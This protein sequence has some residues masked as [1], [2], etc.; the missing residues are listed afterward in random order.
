MFDTED[1]T[2]AQ[3]QQDL[4]LILRNL[5]PSFNFPEPALND[6][7]DAVR[8][9][10][11]RGLSPDQTLVLVNSSRRHRSAQVNVLGSLGRGSNPVDLSTIPA[12]AIGRIEVLRDGAAAQYGSDAIAGIINVQLKEKRE[13]FDLST[14]YGRFYAGDGR[15]W[16]IQA[17]Q[18]F[19]L[20]D[21]GF[22][23]VSLEFVDA[24]ET[25]RAGPE[26]RAEAMRTLLEQGYFDGTP[27]ETD[28]RQV[29]DPGLGTPERD[30]LAITLNTGLDLGDDEE[31]YGFATFTDREIASQ[32]FFYREPFS[33]S[34]LLALS[35]DPAQVNTD[36]VPSIFPAGYQPVLTTDVTDV[37]ASGG[38]RGSLDSGLQ[39]DASLTYG[40]NEL[41]FELSQSL[42]ASLGPD[43]PTRFDTGAL[44]NSELTANLDFS[45]PVDIGL[46]SPLNVA[47]GAEYRWEEYAI[48]QGEPAS[49]AQGSSTTPDGRPRAPFSNGFPGFRPEDAI[50]ESRESGSVYLDLEADVTERLLLGAAMRYENY[51]DF[52]ETLNGKVSARYEVN[53]MLALRGSASTGFRA[54][55]LAQSYFTRIQAV[56]DADTNE[57]EETGVFPVSSQAAQAFGAQELEPEDSVNFTGGF[58]VEPFPGG[59]FEFDLYQIQLE[60]RIILTETLE[61]DAAERATLD[62]IGLS[63]VQAVQFFVNGVD[64]TNV[65]LDVTGSVE[66]DLGE[67]G[68]LRL[69]VGFNYNKAEVDEVLTPQRADPTQEL[70]SRREIGFIEDTQPQIRANVTATYTYREDFSATLRVNDFSSFTVRDDLDGS[71]QDEYF[72]GSTTIDLEAS[73]QLNDQIRIAAGANNLTDE[74]VEDSTFYDWIR[75]DGRSPIGFNGGFWYLRMDARF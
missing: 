26:P 10:T 58:V 18:G 29:P 73:Y 22:A 65:G 21:R 20:T 5:V 45:Q 39:Y 16:S 64:S 28:P 67:H 70:V 31:L 60:N 27:F 25:D 52:G 74:V 2:V 37:S 23:T 43:S 33:T 1:L 62:A 13:G 48:E 36:Q 12:N 69:A 14:Q 44:R 8:P 54:P 50:E 38:F 7:T 56:L 61:P 41:D 46:A 15:Q 34:D 11:M 57:V 4:P 75:F 17:T 6:A 49:Y 24:G 42:N 32:N 3:G 51:S 30:S 19:S 40:Q 35:P 59:S 53:D 9:A 55:T 47:F 71:V 72:D 68:V 66:G 63:T